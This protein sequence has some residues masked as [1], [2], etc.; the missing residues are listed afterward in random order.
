M[1]GLG[2]GF[3][4]IVSVY[5]LGLDGEFFTDKYNKSKDNHEYSWV[6]LINN[7]VRLTREGLIYD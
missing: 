1:L 4:F 6:L 7:N 2:L 3:G 5:D